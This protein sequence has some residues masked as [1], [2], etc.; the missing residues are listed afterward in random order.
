M[1]A[2]VL[3]LNNNPY[4]VIAGEHPKEETLKNG[5]TM[6]LDLTGGEWT[7][8]AKR[9][10][11]GNHHAAEVINNKLYLFGGLSGG[12]QDLQIGTLVPGTA[13]VD[14]S[15]KMGAPL[16]FASGSASTALISGMVW[17]CSI[18]L[19]AHVVLRFNIHVYL[20]EFNNFK[21]C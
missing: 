14:I 21:H 1:G 9:P 4:L 13:G 15:W 11:I 20:A 5:V 19:A 6:I 12:E 17:P 18:L 10:S 7:E 8:A 2:G 16:P 3:K